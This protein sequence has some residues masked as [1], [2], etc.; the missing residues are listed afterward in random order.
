[1]RAEKLKRKEENEEDGR[2]DGKRAREAGLYS[3]SGGEAAPC[4]KGAR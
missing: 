3:G 1:M 2:K 4:P